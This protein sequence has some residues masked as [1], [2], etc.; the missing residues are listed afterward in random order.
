VPNSLYLFGT[1]GVPAQGVSGILTVNVANLSNLSFAAFSWKG[2]SPI[3][4][5]VKITDELA[6]P[7]PDALPMFGA[8]LLVLA[9]FAAWSRRAGRG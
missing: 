5:T 1:V 9:G 2:V 4:G 3:S 6:T 7:L 8:A